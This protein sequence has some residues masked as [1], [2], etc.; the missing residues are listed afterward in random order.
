MTTTKSS[1]LVVGANGYIGL[2]V[3]RA[4][5][6]AGWRV[7]GLVRR[8]EAAPALYAAEVTPII[9]TLSDESLPQKLY[10][11]TTTFD[12]IVGCVEPPDYS[13]YYQQLTAL[14]R[15]IA[16][17]SNKN[18]VRPL[19]LLSSGCKDYGTTDVDGASSLAPHTEASPINPPALLLSRA[20]T[21]TKIFELN[22]VV[23]AAVLR[24]TNV[25]GY[26]SSYYGF[27]FDFA[28]RVAASGAR[29]LSIGCDP[30]SIVHA[31]HVD[32]C[33]EAYVALTE[34]TSRDKV[35]GQC[36]N[37]SAS[38][39][40]T[41]RDV[42][43]A[44]ARD[45]GFPEGVAFTGSAEADDPALT[46]IFGFSQW[47]DSRRIRVLTGWTEK[48]M[49]FSEDIRVYRMAYE[50]AVAAD[51]GETREARTKLEGRWVQGNSTE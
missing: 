39:Y 50:A 15:H 41:A 17:T 43:M 9:T 18:G 12:A 27:V 47:V 51:Q 36:F 6:R 33:A 13:S 46:T 7:F 31:L 35:N 4:F 3:C 49:L 16:E 5:V 21:S 28:S 34:R 20:T 40:E 45:Y 38:R 22:D 25:Y 19:V 29:T 44:L 2:A 30:A 11:Y 1:V 10:S 42:T 32:D 8:A 14:I 24:P 23:D 26:G 37:I 48:R